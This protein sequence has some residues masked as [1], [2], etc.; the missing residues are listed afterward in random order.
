[1]I[2]NK[3]TIENLISELIEQLKNLISIGFETNNIVKKKFA[4]IKINCTE[5]NYSNGSHG[6]SSSTEE[7]EKEE[8]VWL[9]WFEA[10]EKI[11]SSEVF[12]KCSKKIY[13]ELTEHKVNAN[14]YLT[15]LLS[16]IA[17]KII[18]L[19]ENKVLLEKTLNSLIITFI[20]DIHNLP[21]EWKVKLWI[22][23][24]YLEDE[25]LILNDNIT[26]RRP[27][28]N[29]LNEE[30]NLNNIS[31]ELMTGLD[32]AE[33]TP[34][35]IEFTYKAKESHEALEYSKNLLKVLSLFEIGNVIE[36]KYEI[37]SN[38]I[39]RFASKNKKSRE[40]FNNQVYFLEKGKVK[41]LNKFFEIILPILNGLNSFNDKAV[42]LALERYFDSLNE[43]NLDKRIAL[44]ISSLESLYLKKTE[45]GEI[46]RRLAQRVSLLI[47]EV[48]KLKSLEVLGKVTKAY[49]IR[50]DYI[51]GSYNDEKKEKKEEIVK[52]ILEYTRLSILTFLLISPTYDKDKLLNSLDSSMV[53]ENQNQ[54]LK[55]LLEKNY[56]KIKNGD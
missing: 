50:S 12:V 22:E 5:V 51:H 44:S 56:K 13:D 48:G 3:E 8:W 49:D 35:I 16:E 26:L 41:E 6:F 17:E 21:V 18:D 42:E 52:S 10:L 15:K 40:G 46:T 20:M 4:F 30:Y 23:G 11:K 14:F 1:M 25:N 33:I 7:V 29:D 9:E 53:D 37:T 31:L 32:K 38:S 45:G 19:Q 54:N 39:T 36:R 34:A 47:R 2:E 24:I 28:C 27:I 55:K 43:K